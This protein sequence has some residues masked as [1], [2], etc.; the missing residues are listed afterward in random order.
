LGALND[1]KYEKRAD[2]VALFL[3]SLI[4]CA[5][6]GKRDSQTNKKPAFGKSVMLSCF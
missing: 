4:K 3:H 2:K 1:Y 5:N 6:G